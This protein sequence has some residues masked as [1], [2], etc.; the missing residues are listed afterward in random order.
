MDRKT[1]RR[2]EVLSAELDDHDAAL[3]AARKLARELAQNP[4]N[5][6]NRIVVTDEKGVEICAVEVRVEH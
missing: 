6:G 2:R 1:A 3:A 4:R 5:V